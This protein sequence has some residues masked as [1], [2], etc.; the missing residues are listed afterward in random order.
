[1]TFMLGVVKP[2]AVVLN[3]VGPFLVTP[4]RS[5]QKSGLNLLSFEIMN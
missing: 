1:M 2:S 4:V 5:G 3:V